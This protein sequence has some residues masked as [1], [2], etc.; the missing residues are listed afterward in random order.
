[1]LN[2]PEELNRIIYTVKQLLKA[3]N[4]NQLFEI[5]D[6]A[7]IGIEESGYDNWNG[8]I[9]FYT[10]FL[11]IGVANFVK[12]RDE[13]E[14]IESDFLTRFEI[15][16]RH[17]ENENISNIRI[18]PIAESKLEWDNIAGLNTKENLLKDIE[19]LKNTMISVST[20]GQ[21]IQEINDEYKKKFLLVNKTLQKLNL[22]NPNLFNDLWGWYGKWSSE[23]P[24][25]QERRTFIRELYTSLQQILEENEEP[26]L[27]AVTVDLT[28]WERIERSLAQITIKHKEAVSEEQFQIVGL[29]CRETI[30]NLAQAVFNS[31]KHP[32]LDGTL[33]SKTDAKRMLESYIAVELAGSS[34]EKLRK[35]A[36]S[37]LDLANELTHKR[38]ATKKDSSLCSVATISLINF[39][40]TIEGRI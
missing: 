22:Q 2:S 20:G 6:N 19:F 33:I 15:A 12:I 17:F 36:K 23:F 32:S 8:G 27:I 38:T 14:N 16:T 7:E 39:I 31:E 18:V 4:Q 30:I 1:M 26:E 13:I 35:Y 29:L 25:Y 40:G 9:Y 21:R 34:N 3:D 37:T 24:T 5:I 11:K 10:I 28:G